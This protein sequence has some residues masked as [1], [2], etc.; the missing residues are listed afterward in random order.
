MDVPCLQERQVKNFIPG[1]FTILLM[2]SL[3]GRQLLFP[4]GANEM[5]F[6]ARRRGILQELNR[7]PR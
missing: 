2:P 6:P 5:L 7:C 1:D 3:V 4:V